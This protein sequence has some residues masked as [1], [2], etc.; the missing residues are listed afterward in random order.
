MPPLKD[1]SR[2]NEIEDWL[3]AKG[4][5][6]E[7][8]AELP[9]AEIDVEKGLN[10][11]ARVF[12]KL[13]TERVTTYAEGVARGDAFPGVI[14][15]R[16]SKN[17]VSAIDGNHR[18][19]AYARENR[20]T[21]PAYVVLKVQPQTLVMMTFEANVKHGLPTTHDERLYQAAWLIQNGASEKQA[22]AAVNV[23]VGD[24]QKYWLKRKADNRA[25]EV[26]VSRTAWDAISQS[27]RGR[28]ANVSTDEGFK[29][30]SE[31]TFK[32][33]LAANEVFDL[34]QRLN[35]VK[36]SS[37]QEALVKQFAGELGERIQEAG[38][39]IATGGRRAR[40]PK[41]I[42]NMALGQF[43]V[44]PENPESIAER[45]IGDERSE[46]AKRA[47]GAADQLTAIAELLEAQPAS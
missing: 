19:A 41:Q 36:S 22:A 42:F 1:E 39:G 16:S 33:N 8:V 21:I 11:Q 20:A 37:R 5:G 6:W 3:D 28:L 18:I 13:D 45:F 26:G 7:F 35:A 15:H 30:A 47:R 29:A 34:V 31:L 32:A 40:T 27:A 46:A 17:K 43:A 23:K 24:V 9:M 44:L 12:T 14:L 38:S 4:V 25:K 2:R 10:N